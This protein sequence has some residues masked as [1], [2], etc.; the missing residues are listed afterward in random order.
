[1]TKKEW[2]EKH[3]FT[4]KDMVKI[5]LTLNLFKGKIVSVDNKFNE[6]VG[7]ELKTDPRRL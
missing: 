6:K 1:M 3:G 2:Q 5:D 4:D 7:Y